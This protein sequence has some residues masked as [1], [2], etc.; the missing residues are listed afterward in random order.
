MANKRVEIKIGVRYGRL[1]VLEQIAKGIQGHI[2]YAC[3]C[4]CGNITNTTGSRLANGTVQ[5]CGCLKKEHTIQMGKNRKGKSHLEK[6]ESG[7]NNLYNQ[8]KNKAKKRNLEFL[9]TKEELIQISNK[10]CY[11]CGVSPS[12]IMNKKYEIGSYIYNGI[13]RVNNSIGYTKDN[14]V[15]CCKQ[16]NRSK[17]DLSLEEFYTWIKKVYNSAY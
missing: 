15:P 8:Y 5:S 6:G 1:V 10:N 9:L 2:I 14:C 4:D 16:C 12:Q 3:L 17:S 7:K 13:D 11:Y